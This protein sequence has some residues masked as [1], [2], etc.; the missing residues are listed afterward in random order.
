MPAIRAADH[1]GLREKA[2][3][4]AVFAFPC[5]DHCHASSKLT[6]PNPDAMKILISIAIL[7]A[8]VS[9]GRAQTSAPRPT[10]TPRPPTG[11][12]ESTYCVDVGPD[13]ARVAEAIG[14]ILQK[15]N[16]SG[17]VRPAT[18]EEIEAYIYVTLENQTGDYER[19]KNMREF[20][21]PPF[22]SESRYVKSTPSPTSTAKK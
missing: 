20:T 4:S 14:W 10:P 17:A 6:N 18:K 15:K 19:R 11:G 3:H 13:A 21:P 2:K 5:A 1:A 7:L 12:T 8:F 22:G 16:E 9:C